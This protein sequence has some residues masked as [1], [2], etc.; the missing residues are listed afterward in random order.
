MDS[1]IN[2]F[3]R[4]PMRRTVTNIGV[5]YGTDPNQMRELLA[6]LR[7]MLADDEMVDEESV[8]VNF[9]G[10]GDSS[11][12]IEM[13]YFLKTADYRQ[14]LDGRESVNLNI[15]DIV[16]GMGLDFAFPSRTIY[17]DK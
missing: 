16:H 6:S 7:K 11:L 12:D 1:N 5:T 14:W 2:N 4:R 9:A 17:M 3:S 10:F 15:M 8:Y 13:R